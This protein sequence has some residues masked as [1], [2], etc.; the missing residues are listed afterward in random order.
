MEGV[1]EMERLL[2]C[3]LQQ[4]APPFDHTD[5]WNAWRIPPMVW[6]RQNTHCAGGSRMVWVATPTG[7]DRDVCTA[8]KCGGD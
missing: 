7:H 3:L 1:R 6:R 4:G 8:T 2:I 5:G